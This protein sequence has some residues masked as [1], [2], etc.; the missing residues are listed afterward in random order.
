VSD[1]RATPEQWADAW[2]WAKESPSSWDA[3]LLKLRAR[4]EQL[5]AAAHKHIVETSAN[6]LA[7]A[8]RVE[9]LEAAERQAST[10]HQISKPLKLT[11]EQE[12][13]VRDLLAPNSKPTPNQSQIR[14]SDITPP[15]ELVEKWR[16]ERTTNYDLA[17]Q[18]ARWGADQ[19]LEACIEWLKEME[20]VGEGDVSFLR[21]DR[22]PKPPSLKEQAL[23][24]LKYP[25][26]LWSESEVDTIRRALEA[27]PDV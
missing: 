15:P 24:T 10:V 1:Y 18:A 8:S 26:D 6:I 17:R 13:Q 14:S 11:P 27:L 16:Q 19:E 12:Q 22:R 23:E 2:S 5:E 9:S 7:L 21:D 20:L 25:K 4:V 3:C